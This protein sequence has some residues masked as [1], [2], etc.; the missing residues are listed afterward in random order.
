MVVVVGC[1]LDLAPHSEAIPAARIVL[2]QGGTY[3]V[4]FEHAA[5][6]KDQLLDRVLSMFLVSGHFE[7]VSNG[8]S[9][10]PP[11]QVGV[12]GGTGVCLKSLHQDS[13]KRGETNARVPRQFERISILE[14][15]AIEN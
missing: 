5:Q 12:G 14:E 4:A 7:V 15:K 6:A 2:D 3:A 8:P 11:D 1:G 10:L 13:H 9:R